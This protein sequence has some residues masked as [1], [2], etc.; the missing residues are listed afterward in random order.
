M[1]AAIVGVTGYTGLELLRIILGHP[2]LE[3]GTI[4]S[5]SLHKH[6]ID[7]YCPH[8]QGLIS[9]PVQPFDPQVIMAENQIVFFATPA[10]VCKELVLPFVEKNFPV[11]DLSGDLRLKDGGI[12][13]KWYQKPAATKEILEKASYCLPEFPDQSVTNL[14]SNP[15]CFATAALLTAAPLVIKGLVQ[16]DSLILDGK[17]GLSGAGKTY[18]ESSHYVNASENMSMYKLNSHQHI[19]EIL[20]QLQVWDPA[21]AG[22]HFTTSLIPVKRGIFMTVYGKVKNPVTEKELWEAYQEIYQDQP[23]VRLQKLGKLP[24][25]RQVYAT[26]FCDIGLGLNELT[27]MV[28]VVG[29]ID[30]LMKGASGQAIQN[31]NRWAG[32][33]ERAGLWQAPLFP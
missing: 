26:N 30:N 28:T 2:N 17:S 8:L 20:Q 10:G 16:R 5:Y 13:E 1:K 6:T 23:F 18:G 3:V 4:H 14:I 27:G 19:P 29:V 15:G 25:L 24:Q 31:F 11:I 33:D 7:E 32:L 12:Y 22:V 21:I 9:L